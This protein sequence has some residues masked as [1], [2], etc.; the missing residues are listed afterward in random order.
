MWYHYIFLAIGA[1]LV[2]A[3]IYELVTNKYS[4]NAVGWTFWSLGRLL[5]LGLLYM[6]WSGL[7]APAVP[8]AVMGGRRR[9]WY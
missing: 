2:I 7:S 4:F 8:P 9:R 6:G 3:G 5:G 1:Y